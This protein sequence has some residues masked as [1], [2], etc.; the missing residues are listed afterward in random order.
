MKLH[1]LVLEGD[2][3]A[4]KK[5]REA[6]PP[7]YTKSGCLR[8]KWVEN[9]P[10]LH[11]RSFYLCRMITE[12]LKGI[13]IDGSGK[14]TVCAHQIRLVSGEEKY[15]CDH[16]FHIS[17]YYLEPEEIDAIDGADEDTE[18]MVM[19]GILKNTMLDIARRNHCSKDVAEKIEQAFEHIINSNFV[20][21]E[22]IDKLT[23][24]A[25]G[26]GFTAHVFRT[27][28]AETGEGWHLNI[29]DQKGDVRCQETIDGG[30]RYVD[31]LGSRLYAK[32][33]W[34]GNT[35]VIL[36]RFGKEVFSITVPF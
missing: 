26:T 4:E 18:P 3:S 9:R 11:S 35:F 14:I 17:M 22:R 24:R 27:L 21:E 6:H 15:I 28:S 13:D 36:E 2:R 7:V 5:Q 12:E 32:A 34:R 19:W 1:M 31:R 8:R 25:K 23:K 33:E 29:T 10:P 30:I 20:R 16:R